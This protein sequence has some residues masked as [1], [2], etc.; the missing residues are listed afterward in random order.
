MRPQRTPQSPGPAV[1]IGVG[2]DTSRYGHYA[3]FLRDDLQPAAAELQF[4]ECE[5]TATP[6]KKV[7]GRSATLVQVIHP[8]PHPQFKFHAARLFLEWLLSHDYAEA[9]AEWTLEPVRADAPPLEGTMPLKDIKLLSLTTAE[10]A[11]GI[12]EI[13]EQWRDTFGG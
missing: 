11:K 8:K 13:V 12:P 5:V 1:R 10:I 3:A 7:E 4:A 9:C 6:G 2:I